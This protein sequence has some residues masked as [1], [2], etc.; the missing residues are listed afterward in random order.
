[1]VKHNAKLDQIFGALADP[2]RRTIIR[3]L[4]EAPRIA[5]ELGTPRRISSPAISKH[6]RVLERSGLVRGTKKGRFVEYRLTGPAFIEA[7]IWLTAMRSFWD[8]RFTNLKK[9]V[10]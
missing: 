5:S 7:V 4:M 2:T 9:R 8:Q 1:M 3:Q 6:L 10:S